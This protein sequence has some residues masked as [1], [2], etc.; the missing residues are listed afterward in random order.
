MPRRDQAVGAGAAG[1]FAGFV[2]SCQAELE[3]LRRA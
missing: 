1:D 3:Q 2:F